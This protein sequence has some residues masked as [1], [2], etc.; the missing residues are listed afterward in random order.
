MATAAIF[1][2]CLPA[3]SGKKTAYVIGEEAGLV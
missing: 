2:S 3:N 1:L